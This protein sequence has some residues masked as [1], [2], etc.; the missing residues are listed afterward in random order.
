[1]FKK[2]MWMIVG[3]IFLSGA[4]FGGLYAYDSYKASDS[5]EVLAEENSNYGN[6]AG[7]VI[8]EMVLGYDIMN[9]QLRT[10]SD[11]WNEAIDSGGDFNTAI[12]DEI[13][14]YKSTLTKAQVDTHSDRI[15]SNMSEIKN[16]PEEYESIYVGIR[17]MYSEW[18]KLKEQTESP[19]GSLIEFNRNVNDIEQEFKRALEE[20]KIDMDKDVQDGMQ[21]RVDFY[22]R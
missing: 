20:V 5:S 22:G 11:V 18:V 21:E 17:E 12:N 19:T 4:T 3:A 9:E 8:G 7:M 1:M 15:L 13:S 6:K 10:Y 2:L 14:K 16:P